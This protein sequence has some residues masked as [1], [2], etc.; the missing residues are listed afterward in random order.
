PHAR[1]SAYDGQQQPAAEPSVV[2][3]ADMEATDPG[4]VGRGRSDDR[5][6]SPPAPRGSSPLSGRDQPQSA[7]PRGDDERLPDDVSVRAARLARIQAEIA[8]GTYETAEKLDLAVERLLRE[9][10]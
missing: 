6:G 3:E 8:A 9:M 7:D 4:S 2:G 1:T 10:R 5:T